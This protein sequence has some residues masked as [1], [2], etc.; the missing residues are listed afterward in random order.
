MVLTPNNYEEYFARR[1]KVII[2]MLE[3]AQIQYLNLR[4]AVVKHLSHYPLQSLRAS[5][6]NG[7]P[8]SLVTEVFAT[9]VFNPVSYTHLTLPTM[10]SV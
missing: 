5:R 9:E 6:A 7:H 8:G 10:D 1:Y 3:Q 2:P 4:P